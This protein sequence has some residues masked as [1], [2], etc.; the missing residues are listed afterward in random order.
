[1]LWLLQRGIPHPS[2][3]NRRQFSTDIRTVLDTIGIPYKT[4]KSL[5]ATAVLMVLQSKMNY[6]N[7][8]NRRT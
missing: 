5:M 8:I 4:G 2:E 3:L 7:N 6:I 1:M